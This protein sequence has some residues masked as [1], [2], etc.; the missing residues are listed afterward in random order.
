MNLAK[1]VWT[2]LVCV[3]GTEDVDVAT[4]LELSRLNFSF[5]KKKLLSVKDNTQESSATAST[6][7]GVGVHRKEVVPEQRNKSQHS[8]LSSSATVKCAYCSNTQDCNLDH[9]AQH[10]RV[11]WRWLV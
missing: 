4:T 6:P 11:E 2:G 10:L 3:H 8:H 7:T 1:F 5:I 9:H